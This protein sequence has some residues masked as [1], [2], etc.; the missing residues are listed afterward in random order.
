MAD[1]YET[2]NNAVASIKGLA[3]RFKDTGNN[4]FAEVVAAAP[5]G[6]KYVSVPASSASGT[7]L[8]SGAI[9]DLLSG[10]VIVPGT[11]TPGVVQIK[12]GTG[13]AITIFAGGT[14]ADLSPITVPLN[15]RA[16]GAG[17]K[18]ITGA[19]VT[20]LASGEF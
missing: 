7:A 19:N 15:I 18:I 17:W 9:G 2:I 1:R 3:K 13:A 8:G 4:T 10:L 12:D 5:V 11:T 20:V 6:T 16:T 14:L